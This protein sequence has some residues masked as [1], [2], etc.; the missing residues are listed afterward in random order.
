M[1]FCSIFT[2]MC[3][4]KITIFVW[5][6]ALATKHQP[7]I[8]SPRLKKEVSQSFF[9]PNNYEIHFG[10]RRFNYVWGNDVL[11]VSYSW[12]EKIR[13]SSIVTLQCNTVKQMGKDVLQAVLGMWQDITRIVWG[14]SCPTTTTHIDVVVGTSVQPSLP[15][16]YHL[17]RNLS[18]RGHLRDFTECME[19]TMHRLDFHVALRS[20]STLWDAY[21]SRQWKI[22]YHLLALTKAAWRVIKI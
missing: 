14:N 6:R 15:C 11:S 21:K 1:H 17:Q 10:R 7:I 18:Y 12:T 13:D 3:N 2:D 9:S 19:V 22:T 20:D 4:Y 5:L 8:F 16:P